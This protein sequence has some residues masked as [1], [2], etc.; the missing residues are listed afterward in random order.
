LPIV[1]TREEVRGVLAEI[2]EAPRLMATLLY[3]AG[4]RLLECARLR[5]Q[6][7]DIGRNQIVVRSGK[8]NKD[9]LMTLPATISMMEFVRITPYAAEFPVLGNTGLVWG[10]YGQTTK[11]K[12]VG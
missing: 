6:D 4:L 5:V 8:G 11:Q 12:T 3:G 2:H 10:H 7:I 9:R 1:L